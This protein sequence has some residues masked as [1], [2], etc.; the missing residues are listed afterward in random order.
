[1]L[2]AIA[3]QPRAKDL[4]AGLS[5]DDSALHKATAFANRFGEKINEHE[6]EQ[7]EH[8]KLAS[9]ENEQGKTHAK[10]VH[11]NMDGENMGKEKQ[12]SKVQP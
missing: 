8:A 5:R 10:L 1:M 3:R 9:G 4:S 12:H 11:A 6:L 7:K 2:G